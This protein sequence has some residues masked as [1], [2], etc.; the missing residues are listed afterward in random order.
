ME[1]G[2]ILDTIVTNVRTC[3]WRS[4]QIVGHTD[5]AGT[6]SY[7][8][9][10]SQRRADAVQAALVA[11]GVAPGAMTASALGESRPRVVLADGTRSPQ[12]RRVEISAE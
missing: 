8:V 3:G 5:Q 6:D 4:F 11:R 1:A 12:N 10:L 2:Q 7:N 9:A